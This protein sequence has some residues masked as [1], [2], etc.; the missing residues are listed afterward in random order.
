LVSAA[1]DWQV[2]EGR[3]EG[4]IRYGVAEAIRK[5]RMSTEEGPDSSLNDSESEQLLRQMRQNSGTREYDGVKGDLIMGRH[6]WKEY[7]RGLHEGWL[8]PI[9]NPVADIDPKSAKRAQ[10][11]TNSDQTPE[12]LENVI[13][14]AETDVESEKID[15]TTNTEGDS[16]DKSGT[17]A[18][19]P[20][21][22]I[23][24]PDYTTASLPPS[25]PE[26]FQPVT[27][28]PFPHLMGFL[29][30]PVR[31]WRFLNQRYLAD[32]LGQRTAEMVLAESLREFKK[33]SRTESDENLGELTSPSTNEQIIW[34]QSNLLQN[35]E[36][37]WHKSVRK[38]E[39]IVGKEDLWKDEMIFDDRLANRMRKFTSAQ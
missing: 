29:G 12:S 20:L 25:I 6:T 32:E 37:E 2:I 33:V 3:K 36:K 7:I 8:G 38:R 27:I 14:K 11:S 13:A 31:L 16:Q 35:E 28:L 30:T 4:D 23:S 15:E 19:K 22:Y 26:Y 1:L 18:P 5:H 21:P 24:T 17:K 9:R 10:G 34:E 39:K